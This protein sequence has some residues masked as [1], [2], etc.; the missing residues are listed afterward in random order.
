MLGSDD[1]KARLYVQGMAPVGNTPAE[2]AAAMDEESAHWAKVIRK[3]KLR[4]T[5]G[6]GARNE[7]KVDP[8]ASRGSRAR[9]STSAR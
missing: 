3:R 9:S 5:E 6:Q 4:R 7:M 8:Q 2:F 1:I